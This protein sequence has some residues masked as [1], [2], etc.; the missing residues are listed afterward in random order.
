MHKCSEP[1]AFGLS[2][3]D[4]LKGLSRKTGP[5]AIY[6]VGKEGDDTVTEETL[7]KAIVEAIGEEVARRVSAKLIALQ[8]KALVVCTASTMGFSQWIVGLQQL[9]QEG[10]TFDLYL[11]ENAAKI[12]Q[13]SA[14]RSAVSFGKVWSGETE[15]PPEAIAASYYTILVPAMTVNTAAKIANSFC[16]N[17]ASRLIMNS[18]MKGKNVIIAVDGCCPDNEER[19]AKGYRMTEP[20]KA[21][22]RE[23]LVRMRDFGAVLTTAGKLSS[24]T[25]RVIGASH[26][27]APAAPCAALTKAAAAPKKAAPTSSKVTRKILGRQDVVN[28]P[29][30]SVLHIPAG[31]QITQLAMDIVRVRNIQVVR[32]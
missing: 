28:L 9:E 8:K 19:A 13:V 18:M 32:D 21:Q 6:G 12:L 15:L 2:A 27:E 17:P 7:R 14:I 25:L 26:T 16:D 4:G 22:L 30:G 31:S 11:S 20:L 10:F 1:T 29:E 3:T 5:C 23:N 24:K